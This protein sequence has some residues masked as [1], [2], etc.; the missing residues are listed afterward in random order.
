MRIDFPTTKHR[1]TRVNPRLLLL[2]AFALISIPAA[3]AQNAASLVGKHTA[4]LVFVSDAG[5][6]GAGSGFV[7]E[8]RGKPALFT[9]IH[10][11][12]G[13]QTPRFTRLDKTAVQTVGA[14]SLAVGHDILHYALP[15]DAPM[16]TLVAATNIENVAAI[17]DE[18]FVL[19][20]S[21]GARVIAPLSG[22]IAGLGPDLIEVT[23]EFV[24][25]NS[26]SPIIHAKTGLV[27]GIATYL[28]VRDQQWLSGDSKAPKVR[29]FGYRLDSV[30]NWQPVDWPTFAKDRAEVEKVQKLTADLTFLLKDLRDGSINFA[31]HTNPAIAPHVKA[32]AEKVAS[33]ARISASDHAAAVTT[34]L[35]FMRSASQQDIADAG[36]RIRYDY[37]QRALADEKNVRTQITEIFDTLVKKLH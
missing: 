7:C 33:S 10:V 31:Q 14:P 19:G 35:R 11:A 36:R 28:T 6:G 4:N 8:F 18:V 22:T 21:E 15:P 37:Y 2:S 13:M 12:A 16:P 5:S 32:F 25:G 34:F 17:G 23:A 27:L 30:K 26:G 20:N 24:P 1:L 29:R 9:N 3:S